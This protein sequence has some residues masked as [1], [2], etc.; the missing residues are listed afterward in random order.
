VF[1][2][3]KSNSLLTLKP[4]KQVLVTLEMAFNLKQI[5]GINDALDD[6]RNDLDFLAGDD[7]DGEE[8]QC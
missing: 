3:D 6:N 1:T 5:Y 7:G 2:I 4:V 8:G